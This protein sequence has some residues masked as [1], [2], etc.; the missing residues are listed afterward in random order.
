MRASRASAPTATR[1][2]IAAASIAAMVVLVSA[3]T[4][5][6]EQ[7]PPQ[8]S[9]AAPSPSPTWFGPEIT[10]EAAYERIPL[11]GTEDLRLIWEVPELA[12]PDEAE[13]LLA[14]RRFMAL[15]LVRHSVVKPNEYAYLYQYVATHSYMDIYP[16]GGP[17][18]RPTNRPDVGT[19][20]IWVMAV[21]RLAP[22]EIQVETC[23]D[24]GWLHELPGPTDV[25]RMPRSP[26]ERYRVLLERGGDGVERWL[27]DG[28]NPN[29]DDELGP[30]AV[31]RC[32]SWATHTPP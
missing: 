3:C 16:P 29:A 6:Q 19:V 9:S 4:G 25:P 26:L 15:D 18:L 31:A 22:A 28:V 7:L 27:V 20:W 1:A 24:I 21:R 14:T 8:P 11:A 30:E 5:V 2:R 32:D 10:F 12:D 23:T 13:A 17:D